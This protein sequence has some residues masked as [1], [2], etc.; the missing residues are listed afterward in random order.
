ML[1]SEIRHSQRKRSTLVL[2]SVLASL[3]SAHADSPVLNSVSGDTI[4]GSIETG[5]VF[6]DGVYLPP[7]YVI[8]FD[9]E[10][11]TL[12][13]RRCFQVPPA[14]AIRTEESRFREPQSDALQNCDL[15]AEEALTT[16]QMDGIIVTD[17][18]GQ[19]LRLL[20]G[21]DAYTFCEAM[22][23]EDKSDALTQ[24]FLRLSRDESRFEMWRSWF[25][26]HKPQN[27]LREFLEVQLAQF[28]EAESKDQARIAAVARLES[29]SYPLTLAGML[30]GVIGLGHVLKWTVRS[31]VLEQTSGHGK[32]I[33]HCVGLALLLMLAMSAVDLAWTILA[34]QAGVMREVNPL[35]AGLIHSPLHLAIL[36]VTATSLGCGIL[37]AC[38]HSHQVQNATWWMCLVCVLLTFRWVVFNSVI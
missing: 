26:S 31:V 8:R 2:V 38:R 32:Q 29:C 27:E 17:S 12:N 28:Q 15:A 9:D 14:Q 11:V 24:A 25:L 10:T 4:D 16:L 21:G 22:L 1:A 3:A 34:G 33:A 20:N 30:L 35:A 13:Q 19:N 36:K 37:Y 23:A 7:P 5:A 18:T 6:I